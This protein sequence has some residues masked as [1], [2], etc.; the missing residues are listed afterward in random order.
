ME[1]DLPRFE[2]NSVPIR[3]FSIRST[4]T[5]PKTDFDSSKLPRYED[6]ELLGRFLRKCMRDQ[7]GSSTNG[8]EGF[9]PPALLNIVLPRET[10]Q[11]GLKKEGCYLDPAKT[12]NIILGGVEEDD[13]E[14]AEFDKRYLV[15]LAILALLGKVSE[16]GHFVHGNDGGIRD[17]D[18]P[19]QLHNGSDGSL[20]LR[21]RSK[22]QLIRCFEK[23]TDN[24]HLL[25]NNFQWRLLVPT[26]V[27]NDD[28]TI[29][30]QILEDE[31]VLPWC[32]EQLQS[33]GEAMS[34]GFG[35]VKK[36]KIH[37]LCHEYHERLK[38]V[39][40][41]QYHANHYLQGPHHD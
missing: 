22:S 14:S 2:L 12:T 23:W 30:H 29:R 32:E 26:F 9:L 5:L 33:Q 17:G 34:G 27:F 6:F 18:L 36:V 38:A 21:H 31:T 41:L 13:D 19:L 24:D 40:V 16:I 25:F 28:N 11:Q 37:P 4:K 1:G 20:E 15:V 8:G 35:S 39:C 10:I 7:A 3:S